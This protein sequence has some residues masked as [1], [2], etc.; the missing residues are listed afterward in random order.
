MA[1]WS[2]F[3]WS[4]GTKWADGYGVTE[5]NT[6]FIDRSAFYVSVKITQSTVGNGLGGPSIFSL[7]AEV[8]PRIQTASS[9]EAFIDVNDN[10]QRL[11]LRVAVSLGV[12]ITTPF[13]ID[14]IHM[15]ANQRSRSQPSS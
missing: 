2:T 9:Y 3:H 5:L 8:G 1:L 6:A 14:N 7:S 11:S 15:L 4:D 10:T 12:D 13:S